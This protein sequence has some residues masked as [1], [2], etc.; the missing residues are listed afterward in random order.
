MLPL[1]LTFA[2]VCLSFLLA[3]LIGLLAVEIV[4]C[5]NLYGRRK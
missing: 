1:A 4:S 3:V 5:D 2:L